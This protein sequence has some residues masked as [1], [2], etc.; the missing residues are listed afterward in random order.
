V[1]IFYIFG[2][3]LLKLIGTKIY[4]AELEARCILK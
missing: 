2:F 3:K 4:Q 1:L